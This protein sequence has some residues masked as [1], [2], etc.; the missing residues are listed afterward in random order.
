MAQSDSG[1]VLFFLVNG[2]ESLEP[3]LCRDIIVESGDRFSLML[4]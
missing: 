3:P 1:R 4:S 2:E